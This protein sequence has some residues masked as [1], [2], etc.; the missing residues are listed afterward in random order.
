[1][2]SIA[3]CS[4]TSKDQCTT[5]CKWNI[6]WHLWREKHFYW[7]EIACIALESAVE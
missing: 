5:L 4:K 7:Q 6:R 2:Y 1:V 3:D